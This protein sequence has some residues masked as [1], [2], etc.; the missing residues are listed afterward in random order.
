[1]TQKAKMISMKKGEER[2]NRAELVEE[3]SGR[4]EYI[5]LSFIWG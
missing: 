3:I 1:M 2:M 4:F 5:L